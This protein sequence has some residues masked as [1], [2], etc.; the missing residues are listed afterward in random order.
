[1]RSQC[2]RPDFRDLLEHAHVRCSSGAILRLECLAGLPRTLRRG[3]CRSRRPY[4]CRRMASSYV[5]VL[6]W[7]LKATSC[8]KSMQFQDVHYKAG[9]AWS[10]PA[11][12]SCRLP[13]P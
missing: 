7:T 9:L 6:Q 3:G 11:P 12:S 5:H 8:W 1:M 13:K 4:K 2:R 10:P